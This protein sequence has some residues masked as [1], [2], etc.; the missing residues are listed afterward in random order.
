MRLLFK[1]GYCSLFVFMALLVACASPTVTPT[2]TPTATSAPIPTPSPTP[3]LTATST[4]S[5]TP[6]PTLTPTRVPTA[7]PTATPL[8]TATPSPTPV[9]FSPPPGTAGG[10]LSTIAFTDVPHYDVHLEVQETLTM[11]GPGIAYSRMLRLKTRSQDELPQPSLLLECELCESWQMVGPLTYLFKLR[12]GIH[13]HDIPPM[14]GR[15]LVA[16]DVVFSY[17]RQRTAGVNA[18]L[19]QNIQ[20]M[21]AE[22]RYTLKIT[23][24]P[25]FPDVDFLLSLAD[26]HTK[27]V[28]QEAVAENGDLKEGPVVGSG[29][30]I[31]KSTQGG[32]GSFFRKNPDYFEQGLPF[33]DEFVTRV[34]RGGED[35]RLAAFVVGAVDVYRVPPESWGPLNKT[36]KEF[37]PFLSRRGGAGLVLAMNVAAPPFDDLLVRKAVLRA[38]DPWDYVDTIWAGQGFVSLG[39][40][41]QRSDWLLSRD[42]MR[43]AYFADP[44]DAR[45]LLATSGLSL[46]VK[47]DLTV[48]DFGDIHLEQAGRI[49]EDLRSVGFDPFFVKVNSSQYDE[50]VWRDK[51]Y[52]LSIGELPPT[53]TTNSFLFAILHGAS[54]Q[55]NVLMH[56]DSQLD[57]MIVKQAVEQ[58]PTKR[59]E[60]IRDIQLYLLDQAYLFS[61][62]TG[63]VMWVSAPKVKGFYPNTAASEYFYW[64]KTWLED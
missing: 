62:V 27:V 8:P 6:P 23:L 54:G 44:V 50:K 42:D 64:A 33:A 39:I 55:G 4:P 47:F 49:E 40:P 13:W 5:P 19:L 48:A 12:E 41:V 20:G 56:S 18:A 29:P 22:G 11:L 7:S 51:D 15:E 34:I 14:S 60:L 32:V 59:R 2:A 46:P 17:R 52:Q 61:P 63:G 16:E 36:R 25:G 3:T 1:L 24:D 30:W 58:D 37:H 53:S 21:E 57:E 9:V 38:L 26:G 45:K 35:Q 43:R 31:W 28:A 10:R